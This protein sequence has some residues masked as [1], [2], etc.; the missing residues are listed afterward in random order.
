MGEERRHGT[1]AEFA[2]GLFYL[3]ESQVGQVYGS[4]NV[5]GAHFVQSMPAIIRLVFF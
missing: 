5:C 4:I 1:D 3:I 2:V